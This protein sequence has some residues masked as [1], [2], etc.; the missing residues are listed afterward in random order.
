MQFI[1]FQGK[2]LD[3]TDEELLQE[4]TLA[5]GESL[6]Y[7]KT[8]ESI[9]H[10]LG[11]V[12]VATSFGPLHYSKERRAKEMDMAQGTISMDDY[13]AWLRIQRFVVIKE[14]RSYLKRLDVSFE[15]LVSISTG[16]SSRFTFGQCEYSVVTQTLKIIESGLGDRP[17]TP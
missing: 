5:L 14:I 7:F 13:S 1:V 2:S 11:I 3:K 6:L 8:V 4:L 16:K 10:L 9:R 12:V 15:F 17:E